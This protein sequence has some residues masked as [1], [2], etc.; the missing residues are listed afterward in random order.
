MSGAGDRVVTRLFFVSTRLLESSIRATRGVFD[1]LWL[2]SLDA[3]RVALIDESY[4]RQQRMYLNESYNRQGLWPWERHVIDTYFGEASK[5]AVTGA[6]AGREVIALLDL[7]FDAVGFEC[8]EKLAEF[9]NE[10]TIADGHDLRLHTTERDVWPKLA[11]GFDAAVIGWGSYMHIAGRR[12]RVSF[13]A[14]AHAALPEGAPILVSFF[15]R[16]GTSIRFRA[17]VRVGNVL[18]RLR[19]REKLEAGDALAPLYAHFFTKDEIVAELDEAGFEL[20]QFSTD[21]YAHAV[22]RAC[23]R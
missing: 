10:L 11:V 13:L 17:V 1:G 20:V 14:D 18:R 23:A 4:F 19:R 22:A 16:P 12:R 6:G 2:G 15:A 5:V 21:P 8:N 3:R 9:G 7:G